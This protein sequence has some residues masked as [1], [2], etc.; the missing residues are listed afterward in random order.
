MATISSAGVGSGLDVNSIISQLVALERRPIE[1]LRVTQNK[2]QTQISSYGKL[3]GA[4]AK[5]Q[6]A[7]QELH[8]ASAWSR[9]MATSGDATL[10]DA[11]ITGS[12]P[13]GP[14]TVRP[15]TLALKQSNASTNFA[16]R[17][18]VVGQ[19]TLTIELGTW[20]GTTSFAPAASPP[21]V[22]ITIGPGEDTLEAIRDKINAADAGVDAAVIFD[23]NAYR[24]TLTSQNSGAAFGFRTSV[25]DADGTHTNAAGLSRLTYD[26]PAG[27]NRLTRSQAGTDAVAL[28]NSLSVRSASN[29]FDQVIEGVSLTVKKTSTTATTLDLAFDSAGMKKAVEDFVAAYNELNQLARDLTKVDPVNRNANGPLQGDRSVNALQGQLR[30]LL[31]QTGASSVFARLADVGLGAATDGSLKI[32][33]AK[34]DAALAKPDELRKLFDGNGSAQPGVA[35]RFGTL[36]DGLLDSD[37]LV[38]SRSSGLRERLTRSRDDEAR[39]ERRVAAV[40]QRLRAQYEALDRNMGMLNGLSGY[41]SQQMQA[42]NNFYTA[43]SNGG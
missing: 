15:T 23:G 43:R 4:L 31:S 14:Y 26:P 42:L 22:S 12:G 30:A 16:T 40:E 36:I 28:I 25:V 35:R 7:A 37:G 33:S 5:L 27:A 8:G 17:D 39:V 21:A 24:L 34:L 18:S 6:D 2:I 38:S 41:V 29:T 10:F 32:D 19:G 20:T 13:T 1:A 11:K 3:Q 9:R